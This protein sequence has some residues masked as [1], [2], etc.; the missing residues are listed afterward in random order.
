M[1]K[2]SL[3]LLLCL[4]AWMR[5]GASVLDTFPD[6]KAGEHSQIMGYVEYG[7]ND[8][9]GHYGNFDILAK[10][11]IH[12]HFDISTGLQMSTANV[13]SWNVD[14]KTKF[15]LTRKQHRELYLDSRF[16]FRPFVRAKAYEFNLAFG[17]G[18]RQDYIDIMVGTN[19]RMMD[20]MKRNNAKNANEMISET[21]YVL[22]GLEVSCRPM[23][24][25]WNLSARV[26]NYTD[27]QI[28][29]MY[30]PIFSIAGYYDPTP[31][32]RILARVTCKPVG[33]GNMTASFYDAHGILGFM[34]T[35]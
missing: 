13:Y 2:K 26:A 35:F 11:P 3:T 14:L 12:K 20:Q 29:R 31:H 33:M 16:L 9:W 23:D 24:C 34:Y 32:W 28:E 10:I 18:Y 30:N 17:L 8:V 5:M 15:L 19:M 21:F 22:Y 25:N 1:V 7:Y 4:F 6:I 27:F